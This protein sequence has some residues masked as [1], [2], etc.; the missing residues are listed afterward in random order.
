MSDWIRAV[1]FTLSKW[2]MSQ[3]RGGCSERV[4]GGAGRECLED[5]EGRRRWIS[6]KDVKFPPICYWAD[7]KW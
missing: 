3:Q 1:P 6:G 4:S 7:A 5:G 2:Q